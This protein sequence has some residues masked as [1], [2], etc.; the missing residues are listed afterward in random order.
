MLF[1][2]NKTQRD[3]L[4][5]LVEIVRK[6]GYK[7]DCLWFT[8]AGEP[9]MF[10]G[11]IQTDYND[12][13]VLQ[14]STLDALHREGFLYCEERSNGAYCC[15]LSGEAYEIVDRKFQPL[16]IEAKN[17][18]NNNYFQNSQIGNF[19][20]NMEDNA[21]QIASDFTQDNNNQILQL[22]DELRHT[23]EALPTEIQETI[24][25]DLNDITEEINKAPDQR[26]TQRL[27]HRLQGIGNAIHNAATL[28]K[29]P[30]DIAK[31]ITNLAGLANLFGIH[32]HLP[33][34][35]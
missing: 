11:D 20:N 15:S 1:N 3:F 27:K 8:F 16:P 6:D 5:W 4:Q 25:I 24:N 22:I 33:H 34:I 9:K 2:L 26:N 29:D 35:F 30:G 7:E 17:V 10:D 21:H 19:A 14:P 12:G 18:T 32:I 31:A 28:L 23:I 13:L